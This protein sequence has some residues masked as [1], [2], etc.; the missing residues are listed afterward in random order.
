VT[1]RRPPGPPSTRPRRS[2]SFE[3]LVERVS[4]RRVLNRKYSV[5]LISSP[6]GGTLPGVAHSF[7]DKDL[8]ALLGSGEAW[9]DLDPKDVARA[10]S[11]EIGAGLFHALISKD[12]RRQ[13][14]KSLST[15]RSQGSGLCLVLRL[16]A[17]PELEGWP[18]ELLYDRSN[19]GFLALCNDTSIVRYLDHPTGSSPKKIALP[20]R[21]LVVVA[22]PM[23]CDSL[24]GEEEWKR[25]NRAL[26][27]LAD[28]KK[29][30]IERLTPPT[31]SALQKAMSQRWHIVHF[32]G[33]GRFAD[34]EGRLVLEDGAGRQEEVPGGKL[35]VLF[36]G[37]NDLRLVVL[38]SCV[39]AKASPENAFA[40][41]AQSLASAGVP[42][43]VAMRSRISDRA[44]LTFAERF[45]E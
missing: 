25:L 22:N 6:K 21:V 44:A 15:V 28:G 9:R 12:I 40:G 41:V 23:D 13:W 11:E 32:I 35:K 42:A 39:G 5:K 34:G 37:Q 43:V 2:E 1:V 24:A 38:N 10:E 4:G 14:D 45:Y 19:D 27:P 17:V 30:H 3:L 20:L 8:K 29:V 33:H 31:L 16:G 18:W 7:S 26:K 36:K